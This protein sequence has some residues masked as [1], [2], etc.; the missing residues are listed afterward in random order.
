MGTIAEK[1]DYLEGTKSA[2]KDAIVAKGVEVLDT[3]TFRSY[4]EKIEGI[5]T[6]SPSQDKSITITNNGTTT[7][8]PDEGYLLNTVEI[9]T[10]VPQ[11]AEGKISLAETGASLAYG[12]ITKYVDGTNELTDYFI[13]DRAS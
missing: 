3:D 1:L 11:V 4:A 12:N 7:V 9:T 6:G 13:L 2:I 10:N 5:T 8:T